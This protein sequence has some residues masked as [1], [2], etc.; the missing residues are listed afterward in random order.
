MEYFTPNPGQVTGVVM[1]RL[2]EYSRGRRRNT[3]GVTN[4]HHVTQFI[5]AGS[6][7]AT[8]TERF[9]LARELTS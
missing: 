3:E 2:T 6:R 5:A 4:I 9:N 7:T 1:L 8:T